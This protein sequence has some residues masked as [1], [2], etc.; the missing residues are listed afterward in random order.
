[1]NTSV[2][3]RT[4][5]DVE[6]KPRRMHFPFGNIKE[7]FFFAGNSLLSVFFGALSSTFPPGEAE[8][9][10]SVRQ[11]R[12]R[13]TDPSLK[14]QIRGFIGQE[15]HHSH[16]HKQINEALRNLGIE[17]VK[18]EHHL[19]RDLQRFT[20]RKFA[21][22][23]FRLAMT[24]GME[25]MTAIMAEFVLQ[26][27][28]VLEPL[29]ESVRDLLYWHAVEEIEHKAVAFDVYMQM[30][31][32]RKYLRRVL[33]L[34]TFMFNVRIALYM[35]ALLWWARKFPSWSDIKGFRRFMY[36]N[37]GMLTN[38]RQ[39][40][41]DFFKES[42]HPWDHDNRALIEKWQNELRREDPQPA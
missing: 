33:K 40:Y 39:P 23:K 17:A 26:N 25:H 8:F 4:P 22:P 35:V 14:E 41:R 7:R 42:F 32:D 12:D 30:E 37:K 2:T 11:Y 10:A 15:G 27:P 16:Q 19:E 9:I 5:A 38:I 1:M 20:R 6:I 31:G 18:L 34:A 36:G 24:V 21:T 29:E 13:I 28:E 3:T